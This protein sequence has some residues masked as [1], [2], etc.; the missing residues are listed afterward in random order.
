MRKIAVVLVLVS[1]ALLGAAASARSQPQRFR[2][3][4]FVKFNGWGS[5]K[6]S[7]GLF[8]HSTLSCTNAKCRPTV[9]LLHSRRVVLVAKPYKGWKLTGWWGPC[10][11]RKPKCVIDAA[12]EP[13][14]RFGER[15]IHVGVKFIPVGRGLTRANP[16]P[17]GTAAGTPDKFVVRVNSANSNVQLSP[18]APAGSE[19]FDA[20][21]TVTYTGRG[22]QNPYNDGSAAVGSHTRYESDGTESCPDPGPQPPLDFHDPLHSGESRTGYFC[23]TIAANDAGSLE[24]EVGGGH[25]RLPRHDLVRAALGRFVADGFDVVAVGIE[26]VAAVIVVVVPADPRRSVVGPT[27]LE[28]GRVEGVDELAALGAERDV[29]PST[30]GLSVRLE[31]E[32][33]PSSVVLA[34]SGRRSRELHQEAVAE[35]R[36]RLFVELLAALVVG[37]ADA[38]MVDH[39]HHPLLSVAVA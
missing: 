24:F 4:V 26:D 29:Q 8:G 7:K 30:R 32:R 17:I 11:S 13:R 6:L 21:V 34:E 3:Y 38:D 27:R 23:W 37:D 35:R 10:K 28:R 36:E 33:R 5:V 2:G 12:H 16:I 18:P 1:L 39:S 31:E 22:L 9:K 25:P 20:N 19:Y 14:N 15:E